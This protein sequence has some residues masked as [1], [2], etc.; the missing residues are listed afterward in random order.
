MKTTKEFKNMSQTL[1]KDKTE[2]RKVTT[3][4]HVVIMI[5][6]NLK[7][8][9]KAAPIAIK[10]QTNMEVGETTTILDMTSINKILISHKI[11]TTNS[12]TKA[13][14]AMEV[15][16]MRSTNNTSQLIIKITRLLLHIPIISI[17]TKHWGTLHSSTHSSTVNHI[18]IS[19]MRTHNMVST[20]AKT[21]KIKIDKCSLKILEIKHGLC[22][23]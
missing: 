2:V 9:K 5:R 17:N 22:R 21:I 13:Q 19:S 10:L 14:I 20:Q 8:I 23:T 7:Y 15:I 11:I 18:Q 12:S 16:N 6:E 4:N 3:M 1:I